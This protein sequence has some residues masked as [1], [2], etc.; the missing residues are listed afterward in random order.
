M[1]QKDLGH[2][3]RKY[4][5]VS[6]LYTKIYR[7]RLELYKLATTSHFL[8]KANPKK[9]YS[10][11]IRINNHETKILFILDKHKNETLSLLH[12][13]HLDGI[14]FGVL[15]AMQEYFFN[16]QVHQKKFL[17]AEKR[18]LK[19]DMEK[20]EFQ[21]IF[22]D[23]CA[24][25]EK[26]LENTALHSHLFPN[27]NDLLQS[28][29]KMKLKKEFME[30]LPKTTVMFTIFTAQNMVWS[31][32]HHG[33]L[34]NLQAIPDMETWVRSILVVSLLSVFNVSSHIVQQLSSMKDIVSKS[35][36]NPGVVYPNL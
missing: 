27:P 15:Q 1:N 16:F 19:G 26:L 4:E 36:P 6:K 32:L 20:N 13:C 24:S 3:L 34:I 33:D 21:M 35:L 28:M 23:Y 11:L 2:L 22:N 25:L 7:E 8:R 9:A 18:W 5:Q 14:R 31:G 12:Q 29:Q 17:D 30:V 10:Q